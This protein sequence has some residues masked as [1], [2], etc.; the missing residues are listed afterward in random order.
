MP[1][2]LSRTTSVTPQQP[3]PDPLGLDNFIGQA[4]DGDWV[5]DV[6]DTFPGSGSGTIN[7]WCVLGYDV[8]L[9]TPVSGV[10]CSSVNPAS[11]IIDVT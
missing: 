3:S 8:P 9:P 1:P 7:E 11:G 4:S 6:E 10:I 5:L 2:T